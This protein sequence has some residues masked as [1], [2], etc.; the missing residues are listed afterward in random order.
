[1]PEHV[2]FSVPH[3]LFLMFWDRFKTFY[4]KPMQHGL[5]S[6]KDKIESGK[7]MENDSHIKHSQV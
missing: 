7:H 1:M 3:N 4:E 2:I 6:A 5:Y